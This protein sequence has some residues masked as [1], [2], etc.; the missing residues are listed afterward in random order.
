MS[1]DGGL[2]RTGGYARSVPRDS[3]GA[4]LLP[5]SGRQLA[6][7][8]G[9]VVVRLAGKA[10]EE[11]E[12]C[13]GGVFGVGAGLVDVFGGDPDVFSL[14]GRGGV[15]SPAGADE[16]AGEDVTAEA[17]VWADSRCDDVDV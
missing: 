9:P 14:D 10:A 1:G 17:V 15:V 7:A 5:S 2:L 4:G 3:T 11:R 12:W 16:P 13:V 8:R 6:D